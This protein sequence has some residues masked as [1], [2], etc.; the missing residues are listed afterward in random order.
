MTDTRNARVAATL[1][2]YAALL[3]L[4]GA[5]SFKARAY[6]RAA[7][8]IREL[9]LPVEDLVRTGRV[10]ELRGIGAGVESLLVELF[11][12]GS[13]ARLDELRRQTSP[14][15]AAFG[16][17][18]GIG[19][20][21]GS[22]IAS[23]LAIDTVE[24]FRAAA[25]EGR[26]REVKGVGP[27]TEARILAALEQDTRTPARPVLLNRART[28]TD[29]IAEELRG[30]GAGDAR[31]WRATVERLAVVVPTTRPGGIR[32]R[33]AELPEIVTL[34]EPDLGLTVEGTA[35]ELVVT[36][37]SELGTALIRATGA[38]DYVSSLEPLPR[39]RDERSVYGLLGL[40]YLP[41]ELRELPAP[42]DVPKLVELNQIR[43]DLHC[44]TTWSDGRSSVVQ[45]AA[46]ARDRG[47]DYV[48]ICDH[49]SGLRVVP[50]LDADGL[51]RQA[52]EIE[53]ANVLLHPFRVLRGTECDIRPNGELDLPDDVIAELDWVQVSLHAGQRAPRAEL[54]AR[55]LHA[56]QHP[57]L[58]PVEHPGDVHRRLRRAA[59]ADRRVPAAL[60][61][62]HHPGLGHD[63]GWR[64]SA[65]PATFPPRSPARPTTTSS[66][67]APSRA[68][69]RPSSRG[70][71]RAGRGRPGAVGRQDDGRARGARAAQIDEGRGPALL[72]AEVELV[73]VARAGERGGNVAGGAEQRPA[74]SCPRPG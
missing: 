38:P 24:E 14:E 48:A 32:K 18:L 41:P 64:R 71:A 28:L 51:R 46:A 19:A 66:T 30:I 3:E 70:S 34:L 45:M 2:E 53:A 9:P 59:R 10:R 8:V 39:G 42:S 13:I 36:K 49:T 5:D 29:R 72:G 63:R 35:I 74:R 25:R 37:P 68:G 17:R 73:V 57:P 40:P 22:R 11:Q 27:Q 31:R 6:R 23:A 44:H 33:F 15:L 4:A 50:G 7:T 52:A 54:T 65:P 1:D 26:L 47:Y 16:R 69:P 21:L 12:A 61:P 55:V 62:H 58:R 67:S 43:G 56:M 20:R 60:R